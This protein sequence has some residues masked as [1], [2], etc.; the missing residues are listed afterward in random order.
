MYQIL[1][2]GQSENKFGVKCYQ[3]Y[4]SQQTKP[5]ISEKD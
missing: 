4:F 3:K 2:E 1:N 5:I